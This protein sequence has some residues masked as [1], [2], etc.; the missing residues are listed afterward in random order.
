MADISTL[1]GVAVGDVASMNGSDAGDCASVNG[2]VW[3]NLAGK[4]YSWGQN[5]FGGLGQGHEINTSSPAQIG[6]ASNWVSV[7]SHYATLAINDSGE[8]YVWGKN[9]RG[10]LGLGH[11]NGVSAPVQIDNGTT[12]SKVS[13]GNNHCFALKT[14]G[15]MWSW[16]Q[17][18][19]DGVLGIPNA[20]NR[21]SPVQIG[22]LTTW[23]D[24]QAGSGMGFAIKTDGTMWSWGKDYRGS[25]GTDEDHQHKRS[26][27][28]QIGSLT[29]WAKLARSESGVMFAINTSG[30]LYGWGWNAIGIIGL[31]HKELVTEPAKVGA[32]TNWEDATV[33][34]Q[35]AIFKKT[36][37]TIWATGIYF[38]LGLEDS[39]NRSSPTQIGGL[40]TWKSIAVSGP[41]TGSA[42]NNAGQ[43]WVWGDGRNGQFGNKTL[44]HNGGG[45]A[46][47]PIQVGTETDWKSSFG[48]SRAV[49]GISD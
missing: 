14:D 12:W 23:A 26:S 10:Q 45:I 21:S 5:N 8:L 7:A 46:S 6:S 49:F 37:G 28:V 25:L 27:P 3:P 16:G 31:G 20:I 24:V 17:G 19:D 22:D 40:T 4:L 11:V 30:E 32:E 44:L 2:Q 18:T 29:N 35:Q 38:A 39:I 36:N 9:N 42:I 33:G 41:Y 43:F 47:S 34:G 1:N 15:T 48:G 13:T